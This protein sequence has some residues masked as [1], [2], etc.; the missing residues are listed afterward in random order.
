MVR[1][2]R[3]SMYQ[4]CLTLCQ[5][6]KPEVAMVIHNLIINLARRTSSGEPYDMYAMTAAH[7]TLPLPTYARVTNVDN[8]RS[9]IVKINDRGPFHDN[10]V[11]DLSYAAAHRIGV[12][13]NGTARVL[14]ETIDPG[15]PTPPESMTVASH[16]P[17]IT[18]TA[19]A[20]GVYLQVGAFSH[21]QTAEG[22]ADK[23]RQVS[24]T[25]VNIKPATSNNQTVYRVQVGPYPDT[26]SAANASSEISTISQQTPLLIMGDKTP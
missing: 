6:R 16:P 22:L 13:Q 25:P 1:R 9:V 14:V 12:L 7:K 26:T 8:G 20:G 17:E 21:Q 3:L 23:I 15:H 4:L 19:L 11:I 5:K 18:T 24:N 10:R 2:V